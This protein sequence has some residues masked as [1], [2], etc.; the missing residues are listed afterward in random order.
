MTG[1]FEQPTIG[2]LSLRGGS[3]ARYQIS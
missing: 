1:T 2:A 3:A